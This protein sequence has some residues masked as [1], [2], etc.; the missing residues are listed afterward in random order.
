MTKCIVFASNGTFVMI[1]KRGMSIKLKKMNPYLSSTYCV[2]HRHA[3]GL[4][5]ASMKLLVS[6]KFIKYLLKSCV[7]FLQIV[8]KDRHCSRAWRR[9][10]V[11]SIYN[12]LI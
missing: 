2:A 12:V 7:V 11:P 4:V 6:M 10:L 3:L 9:I 1:G 8:Q 5:R